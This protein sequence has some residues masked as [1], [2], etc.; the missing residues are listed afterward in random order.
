MTMR[1]KM[2]FALYELE[3]RTSRLDEVPAYG[4]GTLDPGFRELWFSKAD[5]VLDAM[6]ESTEGMAEEGAGVI[7][8]GQGAEEGPLNVS[9]ARDCWREMILAAKEG[10]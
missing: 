1:E 3:V 7:P 9:A 5:A 10:A 6:L 4:W 8:C 2:A